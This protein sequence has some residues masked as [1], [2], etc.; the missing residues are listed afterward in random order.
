MTKRKPG[1]RMATGKLWYASPWWENQPAEPMHPE[2][3]NDDEH[4]LTLAYVRGQFN[5][6]DETKAHVGKYRYQSGMTYRTLFEILH[7]SGRDSTQTLGISGGKGESF[8]NNQQQAGR[9]LADICAEMGRNDA[10]IIRMFCG[11][12]HRMSAAVLAF[13]PYPSNSVR[14]RL[15]EALDALGAAIDKKHIR[16]AA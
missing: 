5:E 9:D 13:V 2:R 4:P 11:E 12:G 14:H 16:R 10:G 3:E 7:R 8:T 6:R 1:L 15:C